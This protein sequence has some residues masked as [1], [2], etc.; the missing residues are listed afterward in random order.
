MA[1]TFKKD[2][3]RVI[4]INSV[5][6]LLMVEKGSREGICHALQRYAATNNKHIKITINS[7][8]NHIKCI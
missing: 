3:S 7:M 4:I 2:R 5:D 6:M 8:K 1:S